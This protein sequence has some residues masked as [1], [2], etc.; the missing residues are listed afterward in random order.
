MLDMPAG[1]L[2][3]TGALQSR[4]RRTAATSPSSH[5]WWRLIIGVGRVCAS[6]LAGAAVDYL[7]KRLGGT[8]CKV[9]RGPRAHAW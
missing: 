9:A 2:R 7:R 8:Q 4:A 3:A 1:R 5:S 6:C